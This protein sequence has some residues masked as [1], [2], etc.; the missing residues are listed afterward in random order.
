MEGI[1]REELQLATRNHGM[2]LEAL[3]YDITPVGLHYL[4]VHYDI[5][6]VDPDAW[7][8]EVG[9]AVERSLTLSLDDLRARPAVEH[10]VTMECAGNGRAILDP[11]PVSQPWLME[12]VG[13]ALWRGTDLAPLLEEAG[14]A[15][16]AVEILFTGIDEGIE[17]GVEQRYQ[18]SVPLEPALGGDLLL[19]YEMNG[20]PLPPQHG[21]PLRLIV[22]GWYGM[23]N[24]KWLARIDLLTEPFS[25][26]QQERAYRFRQEESEDGEPVERMVPR[27]LMIPPG[28]PDFL[29]RERTIEAGMT[30]LTGKAWSGSAPIA[31]VEV[32]SDGGESWEEADLGPAPES[33]WAWRGW[34]YR[35]DAEPGA[36]VLCVRARDEEGGEQPLDPPWNLGGYAN[37]AVQRVLVNVLEPG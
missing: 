2:P 18:R 34:S 12:A 14:I 1:S 10:A 11:R 37:N 33:P 8:L 4:L 27:A 6:D 32:S 35:W 20:A 30:M 28:R 22:P 17:G 21:F 15:D 25:G 24:V 36:H 13:T 5:P 23:T 31:A 29:T 7:R 9:G 26:Y 19:A 3:R 16:E